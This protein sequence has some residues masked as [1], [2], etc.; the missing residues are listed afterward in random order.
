MKFKQASLP[1]LLAVV[2]IFIIYVLFPS[3]DNVGFSFF[4]YGLSMVHIVWTLVNKW[5]RKIPI[6]KSMHISSMAMLTISCFSLN[7]NIELFAT[8]SPWVNYSL[9]V[10]FVIL[11]IDEYIE[12]PFKIWDFFYA[13]GVSI[14]LLI[15]LYFNILL[16]PIFYIGLFGMIVFGLGIHLFVPTIII[17]SVARYLIQRMN[18]IYIKIGASLGIAISIGVIV[19]F[20]MQWNNVQK[21]IEKVNVSYIT[22]EENTMPKWVI[23][24]EELPKNN[25]SEMIMMGDF[26]YEIIDDWFMSRGI[27]TGNSLG[28]KGM[29]EPLL[30]IAK[31]FGNK[32]IELNDQE[33]I[34]IL[35][36]NFN[37]RHETARKLWTG[38]HLITSQCITDAVIYPS[39][40]LSYT[41]KTVFIKNT[42][43]S[44]WRSEEAIYTFHL[45]KD[46]MVTSM[47]LWV[48]GVERK[49]YL[50]TKEKADSAYVQIVG[51][52]NRDPALLHWQEGNRVTVTVF[53]CTSSE[54]RTLKIGYTMPLVVKENQLIYED[55]YTEGPSMK[56][57]VQDVNIAVEESKSLP[58]S[59]IMK[60]KNSNGKSVAQYIGEKPWT[61]EVPKEKLSTK[62]FTFNN[63]S[64][65]LKEEIKQTTTI[66]YENVILDINSLWSKSEIEKI[67][68]SNE[69]ASYWYVVNNN[70][71]KQ[72]KD[73]VEDVWENVQHKNFQMVPFEKI[74]NRNSILITKMVENA[75]SYKDLD[76][77]KYANNISKKFLNDTIPLACININS[78]M[79]DYF[80]TTLNDFGFIQLQSVTLE[81]C[82]EI[83]SKKQWN[84]IQDSENSVN[85]DNADM[86]VVLTTNKIDSGAPDHLMRFFNYK[87]ILQQG[88]KFFFENSNSIH[89]Q[90]CVAMANEAF[91][92][93]PVSSLIVLETDKDYEEN[94]IDKNTKSLLNATKK[95]NGAVPEPHEW[96]LIILGSCVLLYFVAKQ[97]GLI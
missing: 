28:D 25:F 3:N 8:F 48:N 82:I 80:Y 6:S 96:L 72:I 92:V 64:Y 40:R 24:A 7:Q 17:I 81:N 93:S 26:K 27:N 30:N 52:Q 62:G 69:N 21:S 13:I 55:I 34:A 23:L 57:C 63:K 41:Q 37:N 32:T 77:C 94:K 87:K 60:F 65:L 18:S 85:I 43:E 73:N 39:Y 83:L 31:L 71:L 89:L 54:I 91:V 29:H 12:I 46:A 15:I 5:T 51:V 4:I 76:S 44:N 53:P 70:E 56:S 78:S 84:Q 33:R 95:G 22:S 67:I 75:P 49:S 66:P 20:F 1:S 47:S 90:E 74:N 59:P 38:E 36:T 58:Q 35:K 9:I 19:L 97:K 68:S 79:K 2:A 50:T 42:S 14:G 86:N 45:P 16:L 10:F 11:L 88:G 61:V